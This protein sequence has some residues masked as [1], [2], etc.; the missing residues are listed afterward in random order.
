MQTW[1]NSK[2]MLRAT[3]DYQFG[4]SLGIGYSKPDWTVGAPS[5]VSGLPSL[6]KS[7]EGAMP[8]VGAVSFTHQVKVIG[9][10]GAFNF[11]VGP[12]VFLNSNVNVTRHSD[13]DAL[14]R[15][16]YTGFNLR[17]GIGVG[18]VMPQPVVSFINALLRTLNLREIKG[19][20]GLDGPDEMLINANDVTPR[21]EACE[22]EKTSPPQA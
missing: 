19:D 14:A 2:G 16:I 17:A 6:Q 20:G 3:G 1:F 4:G 13:L 12:Y 7:V 8:G 15:C 22:N 10:I 5:S 18:Y 11:V 9:G 21:S